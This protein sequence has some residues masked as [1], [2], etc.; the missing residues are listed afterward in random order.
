ML[1]VITDSIYSSKKLSFCFVNYSKL[2][3]S[4]LCYS[5]LSFCSKLL[6]LVT[7]LD[8]VMIMVTILSCISMAFETPKRRIMNTPELQVNFNSLKF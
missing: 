3:V 2:S 1:I 8:W 7:Y 5:K 6:G 4:F